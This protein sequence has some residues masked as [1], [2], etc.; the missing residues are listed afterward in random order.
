MG[1]AGIDL[2]LFL[3]LIVLIS[4]LFSYI[5][6]LPFK[7]EAYDFFEKNYKISKE[8]LQHVISQEYC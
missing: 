7:N 5:K 2:S 8:F 3:K 6:Y 1:S 4:D